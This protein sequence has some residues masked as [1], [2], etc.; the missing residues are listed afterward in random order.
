MVLMEPGKRLR[1]SRLLGWWYVAIGAGFVLLGINRLLLRERLWLVILRWLIAAG[2]FALGCFELR[3]K[4][5]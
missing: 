5:E 2:F 3:R 4:R 1:R